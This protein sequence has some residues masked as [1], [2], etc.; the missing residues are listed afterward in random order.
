MCSQVVHNCFSIFLYLFK[1]YFSTDFTII[2]SFVYIV[3]FQL[4]LCITIEHFTAD[5]G[6]TKLVLTYARK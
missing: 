4:P 2:A 5:G 3:H 6:G 1:V